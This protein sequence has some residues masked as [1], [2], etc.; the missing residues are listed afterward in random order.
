MRNVRGK[1]ARVEEFGVCVG[2]GNK[3]Y[4]GQGESKMRI[5][6]WMC[7]RNRDEKLSAGD[8]ACVLLEKEK[9]E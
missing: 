3:T 4:V 2:G 9:E 8:F 6:E 7:E 5:E 1:E